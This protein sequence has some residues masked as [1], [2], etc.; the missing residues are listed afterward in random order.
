MGIP[1]DCNRHGC[2]SKLTTIAQECGYLV[3][4][5]CRRCPYCHTSRQIKWEAYCRE[6]DVDSAR[7]PSSLAP[8]GPTTS[9]S[10]TC[11]NAK[12]ILFQAENEPLVLTFEAI[13]DRPANNGERGIVFD[14]EYYQS[15]SHGLRETLF[16]HAL[17]AF[18]FAN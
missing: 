4:Y 2:V 9:Y 16:A 15:M 18:L 12:S 8:L 5:L 10:A 6:L 3:C 1:N 17:S 11:F 13:F 14:D 7:N